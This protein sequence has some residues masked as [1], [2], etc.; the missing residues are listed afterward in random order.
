MDTNVSQELSISIFMEV[1]VKELAS[2]A[3]TSV[4]V[5]QSTRCYNLEGRKFHLRNSFYL[6]SVL[7]PHHLIILTLWRL[8]TPIVVVPHR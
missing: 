8:K 4:P 1:T 2:Y 5:Y 7:Y 6:P 3:K